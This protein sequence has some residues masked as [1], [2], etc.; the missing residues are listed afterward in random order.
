MTAAEAI[1]ELQWIREHGF[2]AD[3][4]I[5]GTERINEALDIAI[6][7]VSK[8]VPK[9]VLIKEYNPAFCPNCG[10]ELSTHLGDG[11]YRHWSYKEKCPECCQKLKWSEEK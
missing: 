3:S 4:K 1:K 5:V 7:E 9:L 2:V 10:A 8:E 6:K 11:Y